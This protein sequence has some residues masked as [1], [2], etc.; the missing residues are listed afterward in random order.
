MLLGVPLVI[1]GLVF[2][3]NH[4]AYGSNFYSGQQ[5]DLQ[6]LDNSDSL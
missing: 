6:P 5:S 1:C 3:V 2:I 4:N